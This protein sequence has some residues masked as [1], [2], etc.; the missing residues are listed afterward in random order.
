MEVRMTNVMCKQ[1][2]TCTCIHPKLVLQSDKSII[3]VS[4]EDVRSIRCYLVQLQNVNI[5]S[6]ANGEHLLI[7]KWNYPIYHNF[8]S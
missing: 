3:V 5:T 6:D 8:K 7:C 2:F 4:E 1:N